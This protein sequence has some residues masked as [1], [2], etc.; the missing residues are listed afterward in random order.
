V[1]QP[2]WSELRSSVAAAS[3]QLA[4]AGLLVGTAGNVS[5]RQ[6]GAVALTA[7]GAVL[8]GATPDQVTIVDLD[9]KVLAGDFAPTSETPL[10]LGVYRSSQA[11]G[12]GGIV[13]THSPMA[14]TLS[15]VVDELPVIH[16]QQLSLGGGLRVAPFHPFG[17]VEL[18]LAVGRALDGRLA[19]LMANHGA[20]ALGEDLAAAVDNALL[21]EWLCE[22]YW[23]AKAI[24]Q[25]RELSLDQQGE[26]LELARRTGYGRV[27]KT[28]S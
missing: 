11:K 28:A 18:A 19:A 5:A 4:Q 7:T 25:P 10:H 3:R 14:T 26:V 22:L 16:H 21:T 9:G 6:G 20:V 2:A 15:M 24:G 1:A 13:H 23:R 17:S 8:A 27:K 12:V